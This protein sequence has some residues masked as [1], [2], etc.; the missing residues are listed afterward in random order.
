MHT[1]LQLWVARDDR[2][3]GRLRSE[4]DAAVMCRTI[5]KVIGH[6]HSLGVIHRRERPPARGT[7]WSHPLDETT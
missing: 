3:A 4:K 6:C 2:I 5:V 7:V 1:E